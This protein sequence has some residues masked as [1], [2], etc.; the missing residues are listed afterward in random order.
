MLSVPAS[1]ISLWRG[2]MDAAMSA[3]QLTGQGVLVMLT[4]LRRVLLVV[5][6]LAAAYGFYQAV[7]T[8]ISQPSVAQGTGSS[9][10]TSHAASALSRGARATLTPAQPAVPLVKGDVGGSPVGGLRPGVPRSPGVIPGS[11]DTAG[12]RPGSR[13]S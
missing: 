10:A 1:T 2:R 7:E 9:P 12:Y 13:S 4:V 6:L 11:K 3:N 5:F 8:G